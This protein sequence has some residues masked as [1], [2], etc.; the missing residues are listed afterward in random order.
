[1]QRIV[2]TG[3][4]GG[5]ARSLIALLAQQGKAHLALIDID[6]AGLADIASDPRN[7]ALEI[8]TY[9]LDLRDDAALAKAMEDFTARAGG[10]D[11]L[12]A[13]AGVMTSDEPF[14]T[15]PVSAIERSIDLNFRCVISSTRAAWQ[16]LASARGQVIVNASG[17]GLHP[18]PSDVVYSSAKAAAVMFAR[19]S[20][21]RQPQTGIRFNAICPGV[22]D[23]PILN[24]QSGTQW[25]GE[26]HEFTRHFD[27]IEPA[28]IARTVADLMGSD[29]RNGEVIE[30]R[31]RRKST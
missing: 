1:M 4:A 11:V 13:N 5:I 20:A 9:S 2:I 23:T 10:I 19:S 31:N 25:R 8:E 21:L 27:L 7:D 30:I 14:E 22:V 12:F 3:A 28:E 29:S 6:G 15:A 26:V 17:A 24:D 16:G 18:I